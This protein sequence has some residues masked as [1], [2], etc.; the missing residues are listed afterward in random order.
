MLLLAFAAS[1]SATTARKVAASGRDFI[2][3]PDGSRIIYHAANGTALALYSTRT[4]GLGAPLLLH[5]P[6]G[7]DLVLSH[8]TQVSPD[9]STVLYNLHEY[10]EGGPFVTTYS[11]PVDG[12][13]PPIQLHRSLLGEHNTGYTLGI[14]PDSRYAAI[15]ANNNGD[16]NFSL[17]THPID[18]SA[19]PIMINDPPDPYETQ[20]YE[21][22][23][24]FKIVGNQIVF[25]PP[26]N[27]W[28][29]FSRPFD[30]SADQVRL[31]PQ[32]ELLIAEVVTQ[33]NSTVVMATL[34]QF[35]SGRNFYSRPVTGGPLTLLTTQHPGDRGS[36]QHGS[37]LYPV[38]A[39]LIISNGINVETVPVDGSA[40]SRQLLPYRAWSPVF[41]S[42][43]ST[44][45]AFLAQQDRNFP[46]ELI[47]APGDGNGTPAHLDVL[48]R[49]VETAQ[50][51][52]MPF[53]PDGRFLI[54]QSNVYDRLLPDFFLIAANG[55][56]Q[57]LHVGDTS[58][59][60]FTPDGMSVI[61]AIDSDGD[62]YS[63][64]LYITDLETRQTALLTQ[65]S[66][67]IGYLTDWR[68]SPDGSTFYFGTNDG[69]F[70]VA[71]HEPGFAF[72]IFASAISLLPRRRR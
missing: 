57:S 7:Y 54:Y 10:L 27:F 8:D 42:P 70:A 38:G 66:S 21:L 47:I 45:V 67:R 22:G 51:H 3:T 23:V 29:L 37:G 55:Q 24:H 44:K 5:T 48:Q 62:T 9:S 50:V 2:L 36:F 11:S 59:A 39:H 43:D 56:S 68:F 49:D 13:S 46:Y 18:A 25:W 71:I 16:N 61:G 19:P 35:D 4:D 69:L 34:R 31:S 12:S 14:S 33:D 65:T 32:D 20:I 6:S 53:S 64:S 40:S 26:T 60:I 30:G 52:L 63:D 72:L 17:F 58:G 41:G 1:A 28:Q 15:R